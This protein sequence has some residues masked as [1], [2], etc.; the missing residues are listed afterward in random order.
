MKILYG[1]SLNGRGPYK[2]FF[3][4]IICTP[5]IKMKHFLSENTTFDGSF[6]KIEFVDR[7]S[8]ER[9]GPYNIVRHFCTISKWGKKIFF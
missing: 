9:R 1:K 6:W 8:K 2:I 5:F 3:G 7:K 4:K